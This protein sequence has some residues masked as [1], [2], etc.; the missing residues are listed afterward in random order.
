MRL[1]I[2]L[3]PLIA[4]V[5][6]RRLDAVRDEEAEEKPEREPQDQHVPGGLGAPGPARGGCAS[7]LHMFGGAAALV[8]QVRVS[9]CN[10]NL[11]S[12]RFLCSTI[13]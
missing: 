12:K 13:A 5:L 11:A 1:F 9:F 4:P 7:A 10:N 3:V 8:D 6:P 2:E